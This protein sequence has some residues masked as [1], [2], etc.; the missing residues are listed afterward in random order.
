MADIETIG[1]LADDADNA[2]A[3]SQMK[4]PERLHIEGM[5]GTLQKIRDELRAYYIEATGE[6][7]WEHHG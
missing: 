7:P 5:Q 6:N 3:M 1:R 4:L 2:L